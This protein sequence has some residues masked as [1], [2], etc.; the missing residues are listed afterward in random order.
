MAADA[1][2]FGAAA[3]GEAEEKEALHKE[4]DRGDGRERDES[5]AEKERGD[6]REKCE[7]GDGGAE[8]GV[9]ADIADAVEEAVPRLAPDAEG[10]TE[11]EDGPGGPD[12]GEAEGGQMETLEINEAGRGGDDEGGDGEAEVEAAAGFDEVGDVAEGVGGQR[13][14]GI[15]AAFALGEG[16]AAGQGEAEA[17]IEDEEERGGLGEEEPDAEFFLGEMMEEDGEED[18]REKNGDGAAEGIRR[19]AKGYSFRHAHVGP[20]SAVRA[21]RH[22]R[23]IHA[24]YVKAFVYLSW[25]RPGAGHRIMRGR[26]YS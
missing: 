2:E 18:E 15:A 21:S 12:D 1:E 10:L 20:G 11:A 6:L 13:G 16:D 26:F 5:A 23:P 24:G 14:V 19:G 8:D 17:E 9:P 7:G 25:Q 22:Y 4:A 3:A